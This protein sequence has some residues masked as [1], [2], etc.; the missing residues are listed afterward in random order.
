MFTGLIIAV[1]FPYLTCTREGI[2]TKNVK[3]LIIV[4]FHLVLYYL[5]LIQTSGIPDIFIL[6]F[7]CIFSMQYK[8]LTSVSSLRNKKKLNKKKKRISV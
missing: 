4:S 2:C 5:K 7:A 1:L 3:I 6:L 8:R